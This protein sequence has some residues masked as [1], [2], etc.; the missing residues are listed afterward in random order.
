[1]TPP[2]TAGRE[3]DTLLNEREGTPWR[4][5]CPSCGSTTV[6]ARLRSHAPRSDNSGSA[7]YCGGHRG[8]L[9]A[10]YDKQRGIEVR[11]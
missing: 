7:Y 8:G 2:P 1:M 4:Y 9:S 3:H 10:V 11:P 5:M 6:Y